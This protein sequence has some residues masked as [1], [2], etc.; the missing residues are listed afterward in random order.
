MRG[1]PLIDP[2]LSYP[3]KKRSG[4]LL[5][6]QQRFE[7]AIHQFSL[8]MA[9]EEEKWVSCSS[10]N[11]PSVENTDVAMGCVTIRTTRV[12]NVLPWVN[13]ALG[14]FQH[15]QDMAQAEQ[16]CKDALKIDPDCDVAVSTLAQLSLQQGKIAE[17]IEWF[18]KSAKLARTEVELTT[19]IT[20]QSVFLFYCIVASYAQSFSALPYLHRRARFPIT[21]CFP[22]GEFSTLPLMLTSGDLTHCALIFAELPSNG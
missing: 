7:D 13:K 6:D 19:A 3:P 15:K 11:R 21:T 16:L 5:L 1:C 18:E 4:E 10:I 20:C 14:V 9:A 2:Y 8:A 17:A 12:K 22:P